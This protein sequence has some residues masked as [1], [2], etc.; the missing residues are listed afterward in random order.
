LDRAKIIRSSLTPAQAE[1]AESLIR[2]WRP[3]QRARD[4]LSGDI[5][6]QVIA[7]KD[8]HR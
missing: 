3:G 2:E 5:D 7:N 8:Q 1:Q 4:L 6:N